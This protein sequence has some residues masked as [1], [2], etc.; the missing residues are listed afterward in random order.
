MAFGGQLLGPPPA[1]ATQLAV[2][3]LITLGTV[4][5]VAAWLD[6]RRRPV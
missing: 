6:R 2:G 3:S 5:L 4:F 1:S